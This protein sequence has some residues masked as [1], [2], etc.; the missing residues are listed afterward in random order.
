VSRLVARPFV[1]DV[2]E[3][4]KELSSKQV[5][6][7]WE[8]SRGEIEAAYDAM[9]SRLESA[10]QA[11]VAQIRWGMVAGVAASCCWGLAIICLLEASRRPLQMVEAP[12]QGFAVQ[13]ARDGSTRLAAA[14]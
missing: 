8:M 4:N 5:G 14:V 3:E 11:R 13:P 10:A 1:T 9:L 2:L 7:L 6:D 12:R